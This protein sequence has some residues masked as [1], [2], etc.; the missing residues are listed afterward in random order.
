MT[1]EY[2]YGCY[3][4]NILGIGTAVGPLKPHHALWPRPFGRNQSESFALSRV[5]GSSLDKKIS[6]CPAAVADLLWLGWS[7]RPRRLVPLT[8]RPHR[9]VGWECFQTQFPPIFNLTK[10]SWFA[11]D[12]ASM[13][14]CP[15]LPGP[16]CHE[17]LKV[18]LLVCM[19]A[20]GWY[21]L[22]CYDNEPFFQIFI[23]YYKY[24]KHLTGSRAS[25]IFML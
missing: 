3:L 25:P 14:V 9:P 17:T 22:C 8:S 21:S 7:P 23:R 13:I 15:L 16:A 24:N 4:R 6:K 1:P 18:I 5:S 2:Y 11:Q 12:G 10:R 19:A 20:T